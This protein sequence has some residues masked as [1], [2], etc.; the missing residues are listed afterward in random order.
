MDAMPLS[1]ATKVSCGW[2]KN[3]M[4]SQ[5]KPRFHDS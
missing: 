1:Q 5:L 2:I 4:I 3:G